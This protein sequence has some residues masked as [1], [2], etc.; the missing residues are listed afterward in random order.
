MSEKIMQC[1]V[2]ICYYQFY[3]CIINLSVILFV[4]YEWIWFVDK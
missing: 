2:I 4:Y 3:L 1:G